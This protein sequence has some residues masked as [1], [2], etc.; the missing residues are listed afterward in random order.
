M[1]AL[2]LSAGDDNGHKK[3]RGKGNAGDII[4]KA[5]LAAHL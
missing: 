1:P 5:N 4:C 3:R 2:A